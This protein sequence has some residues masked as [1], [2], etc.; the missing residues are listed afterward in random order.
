MRFDSHGNPTTATTKRS[1][2]DDW[3]GVLAALFLMVG[4]AVLVWF[5]V[6]SARPLTP[7]PDQ[8]SGILSS[9]VVE[10]LEQMAATPTPR[11]PD[12]SPAGLKVGTACVWNPSPSP[13]PNCPPTSPGQ[14]CIHTGPEE[15]IPTAPPTFSTSSLSSSDPGH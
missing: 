12:C 2:F 15:F 14:L 3:G 9:R 10:L 8:E 6:D 11:G 13:L 4:I 5:Y 1:W 7:Q